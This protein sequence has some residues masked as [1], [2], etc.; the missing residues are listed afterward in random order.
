MWDEGDTHKSEVWKQED[1]NRRVR[2]T[3][4]FEQVNVMIMNELWRGCRQKEGTSGLA[5][6]TGLSDLGTLDASQNLSQVEVAWTTLEPASLR[7]LC[8]REALSSSTL[9]W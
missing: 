3:L 5:S 8:A 7:P 1:I 6:H 4:G 9:L 2:E